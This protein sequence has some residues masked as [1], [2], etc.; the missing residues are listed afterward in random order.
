MDHMFL[1]LLFCVYLLA[2][3]YSGDSGSALEWS[4]VEGKTSKYMDQFKGT[5]S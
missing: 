4:E 3:G 2:S 1:S 5:R